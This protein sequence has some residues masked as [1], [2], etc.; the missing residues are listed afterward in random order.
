MNWFKR[1]KVAMPL[2]Q[3][4]CPYCSAAILVDVKQKTTTLKS[5]PYAEKEAG[6]CITRC[7]SCSNIMLVVY[8][9]DFTQCFFANGVAQK[10]TEDQAKE[11]LKNG[12]LLVTST[13]E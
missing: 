4:S 6:Q 9:F 8:H 2:A 3:V 10:I 12:D 5:E 7:S 1:L 13:L 11:H